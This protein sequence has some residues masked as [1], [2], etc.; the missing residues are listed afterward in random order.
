MIVESYFQ[1]RL[2]LR[3]VIVIDYVAGVLKEHFTYHKKIQIQSRIVY[4][5]GLS[6][7][8]G[9]QLAPFIRRRLST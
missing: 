1:A 3:A 7:I 6:L 5:F 2:F 9:D 8:W 4:V